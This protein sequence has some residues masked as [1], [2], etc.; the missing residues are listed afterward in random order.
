VS[1]VVVAIGAPPAE[2]LISELEKIVDT[3]RLCRLQFL[4]CFAKCGGDGESRRSILFLNGVGGVSR[5]QQRK[6]GRLSRCP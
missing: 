2:I 5:A 1:H 3:L 6:T 4:N